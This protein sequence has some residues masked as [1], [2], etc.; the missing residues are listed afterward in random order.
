MYYSVMSFMK[1]RRFS[2]SLFDRVKQYYRLQW[3]S[4]EGVLIVNNNKSAIWDAPKTLMDSVSYAQAQIYMTR[5]P[6]FMV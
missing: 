1:E 2:V 5:I 6:I 3:N 4:H